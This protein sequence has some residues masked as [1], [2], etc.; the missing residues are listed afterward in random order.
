MKAIRDADFV[1]SQMSLLADVGKIGLL[2]EGLDGGVD[3]REV[4]SSVADFTC[5]GVGVSAKC[6]VCEVVAYSNERNA[7]YGA[8][9]VGQRL[10]LKRRFVGRAETR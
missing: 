8:L 7:C 4:I 1:T 6:F 9:G 10:V 3:G 2:H 5:A